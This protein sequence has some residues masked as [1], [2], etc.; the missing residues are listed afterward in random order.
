MIPDKCVH[1]GTNGAPINFLIVFFFG[2]WKE[3]HDERTLS[4]FF[5][6]RSRCT[7]TTWT[8]DMHDMNLFVSLL[9]VTLHQKRLVYLRL[10]ARKIRTC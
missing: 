7:F 1:E 9:L 3:L 6:H 8:L 10:L 5:S 2:D 4:F